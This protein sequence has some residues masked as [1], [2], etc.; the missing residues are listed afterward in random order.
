ME[1]LRK[2]GRP[3]KKVNADTIGEA[4]TI[5]KWEIETPELEI[6]EPKKTKIMRKCPF[7]EQ[8]NDFVYSGKDIGHRFECSRCHHAFN[9]TE[10]DDVIVEIDE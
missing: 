5:G 2:R 6:V 10:V 8:L 3:A 1:E 4:N 9:V 7:C